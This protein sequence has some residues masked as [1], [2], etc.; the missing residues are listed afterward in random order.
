MKH[1]HDRR[2]YNAQNVRRGGIT[3]IEVLASFSLLATVLAV[4]TPLAVRHGRIL[5]SAREYRI[6]VEELSNQLEQLTVLASDELRSRLS[7]LK[8]SEFAAKHLRGAELSGALEAADV[9]DRLTLELVWDEPGRRAAPASL[10][11]WMLPTAAAESEQPVEG[12]EP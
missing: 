3:M 7:E 1:K 10:S 4:A 9:G 11:A 2:R 12:S 8:P 6:A 5:V